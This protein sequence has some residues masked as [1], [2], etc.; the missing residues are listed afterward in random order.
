MEPSCRGKDI[1][2]GEVFLENSAVRSFLLFT[3]V[4]LA[5]AQFSSAQFDPLTVIHP[6]VQKLGPPKVR[7]EFSVIPIAVST[8]SEKASAHVIQGIAQLNAPWDFESYRHFCEAAKADPDCLMAYWGISMSLA[9]RNHEFFAERKAAIERM[10]DL[11]EADVGTDIEKG[12]VQ[13][14]GRL[15]ANG[16]RAA[17]DIFSAISKKYPNDS[18]SKLLGLFLSRDGFDEFGNPGEGQ[19]ACWD[20]LFEMVKANPESVPVVAFWVASQ[21]EAPLNAGILENDVL[22]FA[23]KLA[24]LHPD[25]PPF[26]LTA[27]HVE[28]RCGH[29]KRAIGYC[30]QAISLYETY[31]ETEKVTE[32]DCEGL[33]RCKVYLASLLA[34]KGEYE[35]SVAISTELSKMEVTEAR[36]FSRGAALIMWEG[37]TLGA[38][39]SLLRDTK[40]DLDTGL[41]M[42]DALDE[43][44]WFPGKSMSLGYRDCLGHA[45]GVRKALLAKDLPAAKSLQ[46]DFTEKGRTFDQARKLARNTSSFSEWL[47]AKSAIITLETELLGLIKM[48]E[49]GASKMAALNFFKAAVDRQ[50]GVLNFL[51]PAIAYPME[52]RVGNYYLDAGDAEKAAG[53]FRRGFDRMP[54]QIDILRAY[55]S[56]LL[57]LGKNESAA[58]VAK[59]IEEVKK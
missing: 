18:Q 52:L 51:P 20:G 16:S 21:S 13:A 58:K 29:A 48:Q 36:V 7:P 14:A 11:V 28:A 53:A 17:G 33:I 35:K 1:A 30:E 57:K 2:S 43:K 27:A 41:K 19:K 56:A 31:M 34:T 32:F 9:G 55:R 37:R 3:L 6:V 50:G 46:R 42:L 4:L 24:R 10:L 15:Y 47:R 54:N 59:Q 5:S 22:P 26:H 12:Y 38:R 25:F 49:T 40:A 39:L 44:Q 8:K 23:R 45:I